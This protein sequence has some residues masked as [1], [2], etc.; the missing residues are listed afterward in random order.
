MDRRNAIQ[1]LLAGG[2]LLAV[3]NLDAAQL[4]KRFTSASDGRIKQDYLDTQKGQIYYWTAGTGPNLVLVHQ[5]AN[6]SEEY[7]ALVPLLAGR[8]RLI[9]MDLPGHGRSDDPTSMPTV[10]DYTAAV[11]AVVQHLGIKKTHLLGHHGGALTAMN[12][13]AQHPDQ[14]NKTILSG[15]GGLKTAEEREAFLQDL[16]KSKHEIRRDSSF[17]ANLWDQYVSMMSDD[18]SYDD[19][20]KP[21]LSALGSRMRPYR[22][23]EVYLKWERRNAL[24]HLRGPVLF[25]Q[26]E[27]DTFVSGQ[28]Q[29]L[30]IVPDSQ[31]IVLKGCGA[32]A[33]Y[34]RPEIC[35][36]MIDT[37]I[38]T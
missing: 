14:I 33:F 17:V 25:V 31:R 30:S 21:F 6:S 34:D 10:D 19:I 3:G 28:E 27:K 1:S 2:S 23:I 4:P 35:A 38:S 8:Y 29:L 20:Y 37:Y 18:A 12:F 36:Q 7:A 11:N 22:A 5:S 15:T 13:A 32:F 16:L 24:T 26:G 9:A